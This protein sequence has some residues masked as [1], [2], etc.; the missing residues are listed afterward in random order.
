M[1]NIIND[2]KLLGSPE[3]AQRLQRFFKTGVGQYAE[4]DIF[5]GATVPSIRNVAKTYKHLDIADLEKMIAH[6]VH[7]VRLCALLIMVFQSKTLPEQMYD[8]YL[9]KT[10]FINNWD[11]VDLSAPIIVG[12]FLRNKDCSILYKLA[13][14]NVLWERRIAMVSTYAF[15]KQGQSE[16]TLKLAQVLMN[17]KHD[18]IH[19]AVGWMLREIGMRCS[20][21][22][23]ITFLEKH[24]STIPR[25]MLRYAIEHLTDEERMYFLQAKNR[26]VL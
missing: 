7:E 2:V 22:I 21:N 14:S 20:Q 8:L 15:I 6:E 16:H 25:T 4:G 24:A 26:S 17:D 1:N 11:L 9:K 12:N 19:K 10:T 5:L 23:L 18:L 3:K 13:E